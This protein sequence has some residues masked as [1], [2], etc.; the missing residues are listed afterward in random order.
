[1]NTILHNEIDEDIS[2]VSQTLTKYCHKKMTDYGETT[3]EV[4]SHVAVRLIQMGIAFL[5]KAMGKEKDDMDENMEIVNRLTSELISK[6]N[7]L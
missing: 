5:M 6:I 4:L 1:M 2:Q 3:L 7:G